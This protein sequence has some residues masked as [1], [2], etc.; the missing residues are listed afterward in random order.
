MK[1]YKQFHES[2]LDDLIGEFPDHPEHK[3]QETTK[4]VSPIKSTKRKPVKVKGVKQD[5]FPVYIRSKKELMDKI[6]IITLDKVINLYAKHN[7]R[8]ADS[9]MFKYDVRKLWKFREYD[10]DIDADDNFG[11]QKHKTDIEKTKSIKD[12]GV[13][14]VRRQ[15]NGDVEVYVGE[16]N[17][18]LALAKRLGIKKMP[19]LIIYS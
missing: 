11:W 2:I 15:P 18:R 12:H 17:H 19:M 5:N 3:Y 1:T 7:M 14:N 8:L 13:V 9:L 16:G 10:R 6:G 4:K